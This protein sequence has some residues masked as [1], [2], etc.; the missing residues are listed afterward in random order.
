MP[1]GFGTRA[2]ALDAAREHV[3]TQFVRI[4]VDADDVTVEIEATDAES[5]EP[6]AETD[7]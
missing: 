2:Q 5:D 4:G 7:A 3:R 1:R 6:D